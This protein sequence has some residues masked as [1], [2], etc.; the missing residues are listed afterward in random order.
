MDEEISIVDTNTRN[1]KIRNFF[2]KNKKILIVIISTIIL[3]LG[4]YFLYDEINKKNKIKLSNLYNSS[5]I[6]YKSL[7]K[8]EKIISDLIILVKKKDK[9]YSPLALYFLIDNNLIDNKNDVNDL[10][11][12]LIDKTNIEFE[13]KN[14]LIY[15]KALFNSDFMKENE[16]IQILNPIINSN[17]IWKSHALYLMAEFFYANKEKEKAKE[18][19]NQI[20]TLSNSNADIRLESKKRLNRDLSE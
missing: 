17:S 11:N 7:G 13:I 4:G 14:L 20:L 18:F 2:V 12:F 8:N 15:K 9:T 16:L 3:T 19:F 5:I 1:E 6:N 10:F